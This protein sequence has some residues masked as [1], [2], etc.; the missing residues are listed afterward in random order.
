MLSF[1][2]ASNSTSTP[3]G[4]P[5]TTPDAGDQPEDGEAM[6]DIVDDDDEAMMAMMGVSGFGSTKVKKSWS[7]LLLIN[8]IE[9]VRENMLRETK[10]EEWTSKKRELGASI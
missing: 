6:D 4:R 7:K 1:I 2:E 5:N 9:I 3:S 8:L 10:K